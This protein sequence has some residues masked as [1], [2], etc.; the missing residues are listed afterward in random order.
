MAGIPDFRAILAAAFLPAF[1]LPAATA[2]QTIRG[3]EHT[4]FTRVVLPVAAGVSFSLRVEGREAALIFP[5]RKLGFDTSRALARLTRARVSAIEA[6]DMPAGTR[7]ALTLGCDC[8]VS[9]TRIDS[10]LVA[11]DIAPAEGPVVPPPKS[12]A[13]ANAARDAREARVVATA[14]AA[15]LRQLERAAEQGVVDLDAAPA[16]GPAA[17]TPPG[18]RQIE[19]VTVLDRDR[20]ELRPAPPPDCLPD[21]RFDLGGLRPG[22]AFADARAAAARG[23]ISASGEADPRALTKLVRLHLRSGLG[24]EARGLLAAFPARFPDRALLEDLARVVE[25]TA[26]PATGP[27]RKP[28]ACP[29]AHGL[30]QALA[31]D[32]PAPDVPEKAFE[33][34]FAALPP[35]TRLL[36]G[37]RLISRFLGAGRVAEAARL[38]DLVTRA[39]LPE[40]PEFTFARAALLARERP[41]EASA[42]FRD[43]AQAPIAEATEALARH[44]R[45][46]LRAGTPTPELAADLAV[47]AHLSRGL[48]LRADLLA[49]SAE[50]LGRSGGLAAALDALETARRDLP[51]ETRRFATVATRLLAS[52]DAAAG[53]ADWAGLV[54]G[55]PAL[56]ARD[57]AAAPDRAAIARR[58]LAIGLPGAARNLVAPSLTAGPGPLGEAETRL[59]AAEAELRLGHPERAHALAANLPGAEAAALLARAEA[60]A[61]AWSEAVET[62]AEAGLEPE[63]A[64]YA[65]PAGDWTRVR[66]SADP[67]ERA[68]AAYMG[69]SE[70]PAG[71][72][73][74]ETAFAAQAPGLARP[75]LKEPREL[76]ETGPGV[77][78][79]VRGLLTAPE[80]AN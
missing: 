3:G 18:H 5:G 49:L 28:G 9:A 57:R 32:L 76:L 48:P 80:G 33:T 68:M 27:L 60:G 22:E 10:R 35:D 62:L 73:P 53:A 58:L 37:P 39:G 23:L 24:L 11:L 13:A 25:G 71:A 31:G 30:W 78:E 64:P 55:H 74:A 12:R 44:A 40:T 2:A 65:F 59:I 54:L 63:T 43:L 20:R 21:A 70:R 36:L 47:A 34:A 66:G 61:G 1:A 67:A 15:L 29:G 41:A 7:V 77:A 69:R 50:T 17:T 4:G 26:P 8:S 45:L 79:F 51:A 16:A 52:P 56:L 38:R 42:L 72:T 46:V 14:E 75:S 6:G 19:A